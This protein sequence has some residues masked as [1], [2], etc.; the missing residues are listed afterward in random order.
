[1]TG[2]QTCAL[3]IYVLKKTY[4]YEMNFVGNKKPI[5]QLKEGITIARWFPV[6][7][8]VDIKINTYGSVLDVLREVSLV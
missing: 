6:P 4:W 3:P 7:E 5:P 2:V 1:M 8:I